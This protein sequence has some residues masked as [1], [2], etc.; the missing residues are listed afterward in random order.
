MADLPSDRITADKPPFSS[1]G[2]DYFG[3]FEVKYGRK[4][5]KRYGVIFTCSASRAI[6]LEV[7]ASLTTDSCINTIRRFLARRGPVE[8]IR[9]D[10]GTNIV[11]AEAELRRELSTWNQSQI[12]RMLQQE[13]V[14]W[15]F[16]TPAASHFGGFLGTFDTF[17]SESTVWPP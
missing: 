5:L 2:M 8:L 3:P 7:A 9:S 16:N 15:I 4:T 6:H 14:K 10:N 1:T 17:R 13:N 11:G 12:G